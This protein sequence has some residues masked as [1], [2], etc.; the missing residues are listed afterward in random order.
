M[1]TASLRHL[2]IIFVPTLA[3]LLLMG[4]AS[5]LFNVSI[6]NMTRDV[7]AIANI[8]PLTGILSNLGILLWCS[9]ASICFFSAIM[10]RNLKSKEIFWFL[11][12]SALLT[13]YLL[14]DDFFLFHEYLASRYLGLNEKVI[15]GALGIAVLS[16]LIEFRGIILRTNF[17]ILLL[18]L[19]FLSTSV[20]IDTVFEF[21]FGNLGQWEY[22]LEDGTKWLGIASWCSYSVQ[23][24]CQFLVVTGVVNNTAQS[25]AYAAY[26]EDLRRRTAD[27]RAREESPK[28]NR[29]V[30]P[31]DNGFLVGV[32]HY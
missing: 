5:L 3:I 27:R 32:S 15:F 17:S 9:A 16:Y 26:N 6:P 30:E 28:I 21:L 24:S 8:S 1:H 19:G 11:I 4:M 20:V 31:K 23:T 10:L 29:N 18:S 13:T 12:S 25:A 14:F 2:L 7:T 22:F